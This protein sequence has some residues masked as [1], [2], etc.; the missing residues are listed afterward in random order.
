MSINDEV[1]SF[2]KVCSKE[3]C[4]KNLGELARL[5][6]DGTNT[7]P[8]ASTTTSETNAWDHRE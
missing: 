2:R 3:H 5:E 4:K 8:N 1:A 6:V 7:D